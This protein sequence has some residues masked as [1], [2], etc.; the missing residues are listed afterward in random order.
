MFLP[1][2]TIMVFLYVD[3]SLLML[4]VTTTFDFSSINVE[5]FY[6]LRCRNQMSVI[7]RTT[8]DSLFT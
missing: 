3:F 7:S 1:C 8:D 4:N 6:H 2:L 5:H